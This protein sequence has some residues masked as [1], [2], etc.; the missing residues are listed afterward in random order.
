MS[1]IFTSLILV[2]LALGAAAVSGWRVLLDVAPQL[3]KLTG[4]A[5]ALMLCIGASGFEWIKNNL[6]SKSNW[7]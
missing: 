3:E 4:L 5:M 1:N 7:R 2:A 6:R